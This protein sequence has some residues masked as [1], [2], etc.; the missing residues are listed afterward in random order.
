[1]LSYLHGFH[2]GNHADI[3]K[4]ITLIQ[5]MRHLNAKNKPYTLFDTHAGG[6]LYSLTGPNA[7]KT[8]EAEKGILSLDFAACKAAAIPEPVEF[9]LN[10]IRPF[11]NNDLYPGSPLIERMLIQE[12]CPQ[13][14]CE[15]HPAEFDSLVHNMANMAV[16]NMTGKNSVCGTEK[17][18]MPLIK[19]SDGFKTLAAMTPPA[20]KRGLSLLDP[21]YEDDDEYDAAE[22]TIIQVHKKWSAGII[23]LWFPL[24]AHKKGRIQSMIE[25]IAGAAKS[26]NANTNV[27]RAD[28]LIDAEN[29]HKEMSLKENA[30]SG[31]DAPR[32][33]G[34]GVLVINAPWRLDE[35]LSESL[36]FLCTALYQ[37]RR[38]AFKIDRFTS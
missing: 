16:H 4:H 19:K 20:V 9:Y 38:P 33:Y 7:R 3:L 37:D 32:L 30:A 35:Q 17:P 11:L 29:S 18:A 23:M 12:G 15:L 1:M 10:L 21:A 13:T 26:Q 27:L 25:Y 8:G 24:L 28:F 14:L 2:A 22:R 31:Q 6:G 36:S 5:I 34:S